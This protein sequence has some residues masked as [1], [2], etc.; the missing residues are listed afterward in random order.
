[1]ILSLHSINPEKRKL[2]QISDQLSQGKVYIFPTDTVYALV[3]DSQSKPGVEKLYE[4]KNIPKN[5]PLSLMCSSISV[6]SNY[7]E[8]L[9]NDA[10]RLMKKITPGPFTF[11]TSANKH[12]PRV[13]F[14]NQKEKQIGIRI[15][16]TIYL[17]ELMKI[18]PN[19]LTSTS[20]FANDEFIIEVDSLEKTYGSRVEGIVDGGILKVELSTILDLT[21]DEITIIR[22]GKDFELL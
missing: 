6:A 15:P 3:A 20:V 13:S 2:Q 5:Q 8:H 18:H 7:I 16:D 21:G 12:L 17:Q 4:L 11:I 1:M 22:E 19:P 14:S 9:S 10:F